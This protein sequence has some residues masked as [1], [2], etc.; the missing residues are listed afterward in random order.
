MILQ[1]TLKSFV[2]TS[3]Q[4]EVFIELLSLFQNTVLKIYKVFLTT[5]EQMFCCDKCVLWVHEFMSY[6]LNRFYLGNFYIVL[7]ILFK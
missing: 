3:S 2:F 1:L 7:I 5:A 4:T 6:M